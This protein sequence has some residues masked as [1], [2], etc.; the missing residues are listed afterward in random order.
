MKDTDYPEIPA[1]RWT[2]IGC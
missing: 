1:Q 2:A